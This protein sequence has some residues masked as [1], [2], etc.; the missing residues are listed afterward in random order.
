MYPQAPIYTSIYWPKALP[1]QYRDW[2]I[3]PSFL[4]RLPL[5]KRRHQPFLPLYPLAF[6]SFDLRGYQVV[7]SVTS[8]FAHG[9]NTPPEAQHVCYCLTPA[10]FLW[11][12]ARYVE[13]EGLGRLSRLAL[14]PLLGRLRLWDRAAADRVDQFVAISST[15]QRRIAKHYGRESLVIHPPVQ[16]R[17]VYPDRG[18]EDYYLI[19]SRLVPYK[20]IDLAVQ[21]FNRL[22]LPL[23]IVGEGRDRA[24]LEAIAGPS[25]RFLGFLSDAE[26][27]EQMARCRALVF[28]GEE[29]FGLTPLEAMAAGRPVIAY[30][31][32]GALDTIVE[33][34]SGVFFHQPTPEA[35]AEAVRRLD[36]CDFCPESLRRHAQR[37]DASRFAQELGE[38]LERA[39][40]RT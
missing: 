13:R 31:A 12:Y 19:V 34:E 5:I 24:A 21:A 20:R 3:R 22:E 38:V 17:R 1:Q 7:L 4:N 11:D 32:G 6:E 8:A 35:L 2:D 26:V 30:G 25:V 40:E 33:G 27:G 15:V 37:F 23:R 10:R 18:P 9:V 36:E 16:P 29:D 28:P 14:P 39:C